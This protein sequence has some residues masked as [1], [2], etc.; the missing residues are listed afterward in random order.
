VGEGDAPLLTPLLGTPGAA[1]KT[2]PAD[3]LEAAVWKTRRARIIPFDALTVPLRAVKVDGRS[4]VD[5]RF[6]AAQ[7]PLTARASLV[8]LTERAARP[9]R[10]QAPTCP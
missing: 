10:P 2:V 6:E 3:G 5:N 4:P 8:V 7:W 9:L 1:V